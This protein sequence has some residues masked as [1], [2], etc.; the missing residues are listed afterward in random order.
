[1]KVVQAPYR[2]PYSHQD[3]KITPEMA[4]KFLNAN[5]GNRNIYRTN[6]DRLKTAME[7]GTFRQNGETI[8][9]DW[10]G[11]LIDGQH[12]LM[13]IIETGVPQTIL[14]VRGLD[15]ECKVTIDTGR[16]RTNA[17]NLTMMGVPNAKD[18]AAALRWKIVIDKGASSYNGG[19]ITNQTVVRT[20]MENPSIVN[21][22]RNSVPSR[23]IL[24]CSIQTYLHYTFFNI[25]PDDTDK[26]FGD[27]DSGANMNEG[28]PVLVLRNWLMAARLRGDTIALEERLAKTVNAWNAR[29][30]GR[31]TIRALR[32]RAKNA[33]GDLVF[34]KP[35]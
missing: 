11:D 28:D 33:R 1:M 25:D 13:Q 10:N 14:V 7:T 35:V 5:H 24:S 32:G 18:V 8:K 15:P 17:D 30:T 4:A 2:I 34:P 12:R 19:R 21:H 29:R 9:F 3:V 26:F 16:P 6:M 31:H 27:L 22:V 20:F 23:N